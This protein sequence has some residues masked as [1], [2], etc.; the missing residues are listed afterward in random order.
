VAL[1]PPEGALHVNKV[2][3][4]ALRQLE[5]TG[6]F[7][8]KV[9]LENTV[10][11]AVDPEAVATVAAAMKLLDKTRIGFAAVPVQVNKLETV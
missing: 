10:Q 11:L 2:L 9:I 7:P 6:A 4:P 5:A 3:P 8:V 1:P